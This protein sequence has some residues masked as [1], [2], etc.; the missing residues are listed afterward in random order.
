MKKK[1][2]T[3]KLVIFIPQLNYINNWIEPI[4]KILHNYNVNIFICHAQSLY[5][6]QQI[7]NLS[8]EYYYFDV[9]LSGFTELIEFLRNENFDAALFYH[10][11][12][13]FDFIM[14]RVTKALGIKSIYLQ[15]GLYYDTVFTFITGNYSNSFKKYFCL[16]IVY[17]QFLKYVNYNAREFEFTI[18][19]FRSNDMTRS[20]FDY[21]ILYSPGNLEYIQ[22]KFQ[23]MKEQVLYSGYP[24]SKRIHDIEEPE[25]D[26]YPDGKYIQNILFIQERFIPAHSDISYEDELGYFEE[27]NK[28]CKY[29]GYDLCFRLHPRVNQKKYKRNLNSIGIKVENQKIMI[30]QVRSSSLIIGH[31]ST[32]LNTAV[33]L[34]KP[35][36]SL[37]YPGFTPISNVY[38]NVAHYIK[39]FESLRLF[40][41]SPELWDNKICNYD[42]YRAKYIGFNNSF[43]S[44]SNTIFSLIK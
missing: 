8:P 5:P 7:D 28:I 33:I 19:F 6:E 31:L 18:R 29:A 35:I 26:K 34:R 11:K 21:A 2:P 41:K 14:L 20:K 4:R 27:I 1:H 3:Y 37:F 13:F 16:L 15:H 17:A 32:A 42:K 38:E 10:F 9:N 30:E 12:S 44:Q 43:E 39:N 40:L 36:V 25:I 22:E 24:V 23:F